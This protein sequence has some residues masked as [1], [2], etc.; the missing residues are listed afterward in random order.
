M[1]TVVSSLILVFDSGQKNE[2]N[3]CYVI[4]HRRKINHFRTGSVFEI[5]MVFYK[6]PEYLFLLNIQNIYLI[7][8]SYSA[9]VK[10]YARVFL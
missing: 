10:Y 2:K 4:S 1:I 5:E 8:F 9:L 7:T 3:G 6:F